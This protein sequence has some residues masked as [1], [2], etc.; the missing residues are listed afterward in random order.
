MFS[1]LFPKYGYEN[2]K[3]GFFPQTEVCLRNLSV[4]LG[5]VLFSALDREIPQDLRG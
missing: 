4:K 2:P 3:S 1:C 5:L